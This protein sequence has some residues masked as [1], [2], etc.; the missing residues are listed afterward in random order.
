V[1]EIKRERIVVEGRVQ[2]VF[3]RAATQDQARALG[4]VGWVR[5]LSDG[6]VEVLAQ[7]EARALAMLRSWC[8]HGPARARVDSLEAFEEPARDEFEDFEVRRDA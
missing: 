7:G 5:N 3:F 8:A 4:L 1:S 6:R 2:G